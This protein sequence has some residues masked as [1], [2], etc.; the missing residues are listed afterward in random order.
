[1]TA[2]SLEHPVFALSDELVLQ[3]VR[4]RPS[5]AT[6]WGI[7][8]WD[9]QWEDLSPDGVAAWHG[10][11]KAFRARATQL[12]PAQ[13]PWD[14]LAID[15]LDTWLRHETQVVDSGQLFRC[16]GHIATPFQMFHF[17]LTH[18]ARDPNAQQDAIRARLRNLPTA[19][20]H[21]RAALQHGLE[22][23]ERVAARQVRSCVQQGHNLLERRLL[24]A[25]PGPEADAA[26]QAYADFTDWLATAYLPHADPADGVGEARYHVAAAGFLHDELDLDTTYAQ[27]WE[28][29]YALHTELQPLVHRLAPGKS[30]AQAVEQWRTDPATSASDPDA[31]LNQVRAWQDRA[32]T[33]LGDVVPSPSIVRDLRIERAPVG[34]P[35]GA[36]YM[37]PSEHG[38]RPGTVQ[39]SLQ[40]GRVPIFDQQSTAYHEGFPGHHLQLA[41]QTTLQDRLSRLHRLAFHC[42]GYSE[43]WA[44]YAERLVDEHGGYDNDLQRAGYLVNQIARACRVVLDIGLHTHRPIPT[45]V[46]FPA[47]SATGIE[48]GASWTYD[49]AVAFMTEIGGLR[50][51]VSESEITRYLGWPGQAISYSVGMQRFLDLRQQFLSQG[52]SLAEFHGRALSSGAVGLGKLA[53]TVMATA[54]SPSYN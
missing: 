33:L 36:W 38:D 24:D 23:G 26:H 8:G 15:V 11:L 54:S 28:R 44:L 34:L 47:D 30:L 52:G 37:P 41:L 4:L 10:L 45:N 7:A 22:I 42:I 27:G 51:E 21:Y 32:L 20:T 9:D 5:A 31:F 50:R 29:V 13:S 40:D 46:P 48:P 25:V 19:L 2:P 35:P 53:Q 16:L 1:M 6:M 14:S 18:M 49:R 43:G 12:P 17:T 39:Y 3:M